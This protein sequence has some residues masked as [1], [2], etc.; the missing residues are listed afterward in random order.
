MALRRRRR[1]RQTY[2][3]AKPISSLWAFFIPSTVS[4]FFSLLLGT[5][6]GRRKVRHHHDKWRDIEF[7]VEKLVIGLL[8]LWWLGEPI[9]SLIYSKQY[10]S[11][12]LCWKSTTNH[13]TSISRWPSMRPFLAR[14]CKSPHCLER[15]VQENIDHLICKCL[16]E[17]REA[18]KLPNTYFWH[19]MLFKINYSWTH[20]SSMPKNCLFWV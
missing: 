15:D 3:Y 18:S 9:T 13:P 1:K 6:N 4:V 10:D 5:H 20:T 12:T 2:Q 14:Q 19:Y 17:C 7:V 16:D 11:Y 8:E